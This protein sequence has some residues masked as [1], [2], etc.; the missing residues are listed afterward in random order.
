MRSLFVV[1][2]S[3]ALTSANQGGHMVP[4]PSDCTQRYVVKAGD[5]CYSIA[6][7]YGLSVDQLKNLNPKMDCNF[8]MIGQV[9]FTWFLSRL[10]T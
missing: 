10:L 6:P 2:L 7:S 3:A 8:L 1:L 5:I 9:T 4:V